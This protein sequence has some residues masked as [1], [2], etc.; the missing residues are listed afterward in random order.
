MYNAVGKEY[1][2]DR[3]KMHDFGKA[4]IK[5]KEQSLVKR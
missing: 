1:G 2:F 5:L 3:A 4:Q